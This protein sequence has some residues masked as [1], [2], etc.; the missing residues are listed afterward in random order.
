MAKQLVYQF[1]LGGQTRTLNFG[2]YC[3][4]LFCEKMNIGPSDIMSVFKDGGTFRAMRMIIF[5]G[6]AANDF[7]NDLPISVTEND[8]AKWMNESPTLLGKVFTTAMNTFFD[9]DG[10]KEEGP[11]RGQKKSPSRSKRSKK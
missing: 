9:I 11:E 7:L 3:W 5:C 1:E 6:I 10:K 2:M 8:T 4:E